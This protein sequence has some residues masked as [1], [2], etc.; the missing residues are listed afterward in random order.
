MIKEWTTLELIEFLNS[1]NRLY[2]YNK[3]EALKYNNL[4]IAVFD[5]FSN[6]QPIMAML[7]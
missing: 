7:Y 5:E 2:K 3:K 4:Y 1:Y 6:R